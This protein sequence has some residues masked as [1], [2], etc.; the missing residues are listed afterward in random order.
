MKLEATAPFPFPEPIVQIEEGV[1]APVEPEIPMDVEVGV[2]VEEAAGL[3]LMDAATVEG[4][5]RE[6][7][8]DAG[9]D[10]QELEEWCRVHRIENVP[11]GLRHVLRVRE[12]RFS[13]RIRIELGPPDLVLPPGQDRV[14]DAR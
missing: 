14:A 5:I 9:Q 13:L 11:A 7:A 12:G 2:Y 3:N 1:Q 10:L 8:G 4:W 6:K